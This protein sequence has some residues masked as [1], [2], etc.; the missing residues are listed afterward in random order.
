MGTG[1]NAGDGPE[2]ALHIVNLLSS[3]LAY[4]KLTFAEPS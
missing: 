4:N 1:Q 2:C 3:V